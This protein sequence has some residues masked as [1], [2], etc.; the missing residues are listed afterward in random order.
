MSAWRFPNLPK[1]IVFDGETA[2]SQGI[3][4]LATVGALRP[5]NFVRHAVS[6][7]EVYGSTGNQPTISNVVN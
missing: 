3:G 4:T 6:D 2:T 5:K 1:V 7:N